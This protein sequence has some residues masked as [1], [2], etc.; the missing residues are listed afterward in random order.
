MVMFE[1]SVAL[2]S[3][4]DIWIVHFTITPEGISVLQ[5]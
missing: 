3:T 2:A 1:N 5:L 4:L